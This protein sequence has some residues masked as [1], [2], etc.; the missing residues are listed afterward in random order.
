MV[1]WT[2]DRVAAVVDA[3]L[4]GYQAV[5]VVAA[6]CRLRQGEVFGL[7][8]EDVDFLRRKVARAPAGEAREVPSGDRST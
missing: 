3:R 7:R 8:I 4:E 1:P 5:P 6:G 2:T